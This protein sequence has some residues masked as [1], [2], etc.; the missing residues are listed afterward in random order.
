[1]TVIRIVTRQSFRAKP[2]RNGGHAHVLLTNEGD[3]SSAITHL[4]DTLLFGTMGAT[5]DS[6]VFFHA[7]T[8]NM[9]TAMGASRGKGLDGAF[10]AVKDVILAV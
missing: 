4:R 8:H 10:E 5:I 9:R 6:I 7:M 2:W 3:C 1:L